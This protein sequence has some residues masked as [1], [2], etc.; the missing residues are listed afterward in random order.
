MRSNIHNAKQSVAEL[1]ATLLTPSFEGLES[2]V[3]ALEAAVRELEALKSAP[4]SGTRALSRSEMQSFAVDLLGVAR[5]IEHGMLFQQGWARILA[6]SACNYQPN[7]EPAS[8]PPAATVS[9]QG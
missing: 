2:Q 1:R 9:V 3:P 5:L 4:G 8:A 7:G 6:A